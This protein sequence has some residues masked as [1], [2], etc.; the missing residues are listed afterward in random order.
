VRYLFALVIEGTWL[1]VASGAQVSSAGSWG[2]GAA[3]RPRPRAWRLPTWTGS[4]IW[5]A[6]A[7]R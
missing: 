5:R 2:N 1:R 4:L 6:V 7:P 3:M